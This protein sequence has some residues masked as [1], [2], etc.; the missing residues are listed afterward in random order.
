MKKA[1]F[2]TFGVLCVALLMVGSFA[3][4]A[5]PDPLEDAAKFLAPY[6]EIS[7]R[8]T[9]SKAYGPGNYGL[10]AR[11]AYIADEET[12]LRT[13]LPAS[14]GW[15]IARSSGPH[16]DFVFAQAYGPSR[17]RRLVA[18]LPIPAQ[19]SE[20]NVYIAI[21]LTP[22]RPN[23]A[24]PGPE[25]WTSARVQAQGRSYPYAIAPS[26]D[27]GTLPPTLTPSKPGARP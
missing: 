24:E 15:T 3:W 5:V 10:L 1:F 2:V 12:R 17:W 9:G 21:E 14:R 20:R 19:P 26:P 23:D 25:G 4:R 11:R 27:G 22:R 16:G 6:Q 8:A 18:A 7:Q 13:M